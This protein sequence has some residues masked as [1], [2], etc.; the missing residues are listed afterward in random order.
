MRLAHTLSRML[1]WSQNI[2]WKQDLMRHHA[3]VFLGGKDSIINA[4]LVHANLQAGG[5]DEGDNSKCISI[6]ANYAPGK[7]VPESGQSD[8]GRLNV[9]WC[10]N[11]GHGQAFDPPFWRKRLEDARAEQGRSPA[12]EGVDSWIGIE[13]IIQSINTSRNASCWTDSK[14]GSFYSRHSPAASPATPAEFGLG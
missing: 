14:P 11:L 12:E 8:D 1:F 5:D 3:T 10:A 9:G 13:G 7:I 2:L 6:Q 4:P